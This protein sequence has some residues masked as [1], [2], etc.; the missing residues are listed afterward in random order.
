MRVSWSGEGSLRRW[1]R[2]NASVL[3]REGKRQDEALLEDEVNAA[4]SSWLNGKEA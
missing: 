4:S 1:C 3:A 2:F